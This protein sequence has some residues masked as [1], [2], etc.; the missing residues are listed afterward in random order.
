MAHDEPPE[1][2]DAIDFFRDDTTVADPYPY[3]DALRA[4]CPVTREP[5]HG[6]MMVTGYEEAVQVAQDP[7][8]FSSCLSV[9]GPFPGFPVPLEG[10]DVSALI[11]RHRDELPMSDQLPTLDPPVHTAHRGLLMRLI[12]PKRLK[13]NEAAV[14]EIA[15]SML[16]TFLARPEG[17]LISEFAG[18]FTL[19]VIADLLGVPEEDREEFLDKLQRRPR[20]GG[21][22]GST[23]EDSLAHSPLEF[24]YGR[25]SDYI[26]DRR[27]E[28][29]G[30][31]L[32]GLATATFP[33]GSLPE[34]ADAVRVAAN[35]FSAGQE[36]TVRL[37]SSAFK[38]LAERP[39]IQTLLRA[40]P[41]RIPNF[42]EET[43]RTESPVKGDFR[44]SRV[45]ATVGGVDIPAGTTLM[46]VNGAANRDPRRFEDPATFDPARP[47][48]RHHIAFGRGIHTCPGAPLAR[49]E[50][51]VGIE[52]LLARTSDI[53]I[54]ERVHGPAHARRYQYLPTYILRGLTHL[55]L[56]FTPAEESTR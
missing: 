36:T 22:I 39:D 49:A 3:F 23:G 1:D 40:E 9:T 35:L 13:E 19:L 33:D 8:T 50:A 42:V 12:T 16:D 11:E 53:R 45:P 34:V 38:M 7:R 37:L 56:E 4:R 54:S 20:A 21:G 10:D 29:R 32:T 47:N 6:V 24:L 52:R 30:D 48:A 41:D 31:V 43:L 44:L 26:E 28:P 55:N 5:H 25:F 14:R 46:V 27:R 51:R 18:P 15:D 2:I 17:E